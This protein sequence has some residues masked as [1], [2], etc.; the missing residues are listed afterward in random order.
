MTQFVGLRFQAKVWF[1]SG[2]VFFGLGEVDV[3]E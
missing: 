1:C 3:K 2:T